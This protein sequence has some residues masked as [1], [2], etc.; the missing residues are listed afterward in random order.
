M[1]RSNI[2]FL[3]VLSLVA[4]GQEGFHYAGA[5][6]DSVPLKPNMVQAIQNVNERGSAWLA[7]IGPVRAADRPP[8]Y[9]FINHATVSCPTKE[10]TLYNT[11][12]DKSVDFFERLL[13]HE[14]HEIQYGC[15]DNDAESNAFARCYASGSSY[16]QCINQVR[17]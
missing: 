9:D 5:G 10:I 15:V 17:G 4:C 6:S 7:G 13:V 16:E 1:A 12:F 11:T 3:L 8:P 2:I 14:A